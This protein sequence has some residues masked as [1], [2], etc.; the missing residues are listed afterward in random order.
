MA[1]SAWYGIVERSRASVRRRALIATELASSRS[2]QAQELVG[3][4][5]V[6]QFERRPL[7]RRK[8]VGLAAQTWCAGERC[9]N[10]DP[11]RQ[12]LA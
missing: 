5:L 3:L 11:A 2:P 10:G 6:G 4:S 8:I 7:P 9:P 1:S 12:L